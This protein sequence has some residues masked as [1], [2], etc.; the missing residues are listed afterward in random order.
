MSSNINLVDKLN[1]I[2]FERTNQT[3]IKIDPKDLPRITKELQEQIE[4]NKNSKK[5]KENQDNKDNKIT[6]SSTETEKNLIK[7]EKL[8]DQYL[9]ELNLI[10]K[11]VTN[12][13]EVNPMQMDDNDQSNNENSVKKKLLMNFF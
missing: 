6:V 5:N 13:N 10:E 4:K 12:K 7:L 3:S 9:Y 8:Y 1:P 2:S 11:K